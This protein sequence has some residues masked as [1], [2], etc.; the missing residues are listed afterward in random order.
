MSK[1]AF[2]KIVKYTG[3]ALF[4]G[5]LVFSALYGGA[6][7]ASQ[8]WQQAQKNFYQYA[9]SFERAV[10][11]QVS[12]FEDY[13]TEAVE[14]KL[15]KHLQADHMKAA[16]LFVKQKG[17]EPLVSEKEATAA[18]KSGALAHAP[19]GTNALYYYYNVA[20]EHRYL[21]PEALKTLELITLRFQEK[22]SALGVQGDV[23]L[24]VSSALRTRGYQKSVR[25]KNQNAVIE[26]THSY[27]VSFDLF[28]EDFYVSL[29]SQEF[30]KEPDWVVS[31]YGESF[32][33][34]RVK[35]GFLLG[36]A[37]RRQMHTL[38]HQSLVELQEEGVLYAIL[39]KRQ[40]CYHVTALP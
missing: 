12:I 29:S 8:K 25:K 14:K 16:R 9:R 4:T 40:K 22:I 1:R 26:S 11:D 19:G 13:A 5:A 15:R 30:L 7:V 21:R 2:G 38:L 10:I 37:L 17:Y 31:L 34:L 27:G 28:Y 18:V 36:D 39:E 23:K 3:L 6:R 20:L 24:A 35:H 32:E 33:K